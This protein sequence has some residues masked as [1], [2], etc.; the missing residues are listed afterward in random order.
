MSFSIEEIK[1]FCEAQGFF[2]KSDA[3]I[4]QIL[5]DS[6]RLNVVQDTL[7]IAIRG[8]SH[9]GHHYI[10]ELIKRGIKN[11]LVEEFPKKLEKEANF[12]VVSNTL[13]AFQ[14]IG[15]KVRA[16]RSAEIIAIT[17]S[18]GKTIVKE[19]LAQVLTT[20]ARV[21]KS[22]KSYNSQ[23]GVPLSIFNLSEK[24]KYGI[25]EAGISQVGEMKKLAKILKPN[26]GVFTN[27]GSAHQAY[28]DSKEQKIREKLGLFKSC[29]ALVY[30]C[31]HR[32]IEHNI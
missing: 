25:Y 3:K 9:N 16:L 20:H 32:E 2:V 10:S 27:I 29:N 6:R 22:P 14:Q 1:T 26:I 31:D 21:D 12:L 8:K 30:C 17:G 18:N 11:F 5:Y 19:W 13:D 4:A 24:A 23:L 7:F 15:A 28:F